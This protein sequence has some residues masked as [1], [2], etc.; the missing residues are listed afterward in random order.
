VVGEILS[1][2]RENES[3]IK[4]KALTPRKSDPI[5]IEQTDKKIMNKVKEKLSSLKEPKPQKKPAKKP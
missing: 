1:K 5:I 2:I 4:S 3:L